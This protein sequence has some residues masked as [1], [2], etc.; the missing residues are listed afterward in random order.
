M[1]AS[2]DRLHLVNTYGAFGSVGATRYELVIEG[3]ADADPTDAAHWKEYEFPC[4]PGDPARRPCIVAP[5]HFRVDW[6][7]WFAA[8]VP[9]VTPPVLERHVWLVNL[10]YKLLAGDPGVERLL[11][12]NPFPDAPPRWVRIVRY[13]YRFSHIG[14]GTHLWWVRTRIPGDWFPPVSKDDAALRD[15]LAERGL[16]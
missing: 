13:E 3:T 2:F 7:I 6:M 9:K 10:L 11:A 4:K 1:N 12:G 5:Y 15:Y 8:M 16:L 14:D